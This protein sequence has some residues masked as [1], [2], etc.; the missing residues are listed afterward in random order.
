MIT[1]IKISTDQYCV[2]MGIPDLH[3]ILQV[4][5]GFCISEDDA[6]VSIINRGMDSITRQL[7]AEVDSKTLKRKSRESEYGG[8]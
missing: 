6:V 7:K 1:V 3:I 2:K 5:S 8:D 4:A